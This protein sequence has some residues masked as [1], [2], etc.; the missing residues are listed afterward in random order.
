MTLFVVP[1]RRLLD[2]RPA[3]GVMRAHSLAIHLPEQESSGWVTIVTP[4]AAILSETQE[5]SSPVEAF[6][7]QAPGVWV[8]HGW[9][10]PLP[11]RLVVPT[12]KVLLLRP[13]RQVAAIT[14]TI[15]VPGEEDIVLPRRAVVQS[16]RRRSTISVRLYLAERRSIERESLWVLDGAQTAA[17]W[18]FCSAADERLTRRL[19]V[20]SITH[21]GETR[22]IVRTIG[23]RLPLAWPFTVVGYAPDPRIPG[24][25]VPANRILKPAIRARELARSLGHEAGHLTWVEPSPDRGVVPHS[26]PFSA[27]SPV[28]A[29]LEYSTVE[30]TP[31]ACLPRTEPFALMRYPSVATETALAPRTT[32]DRFVARSCTRGTPGARCRS[33]LVAPI[34]RPARIAPPSQENPASGYSVGVD[35]T[36]PV[37]R[38]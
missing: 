5:S 37:H 35:C 28:A 11:D 16:L 30:P 22:I 33:R 13:P 29:L 20:A 38:S 19:E 14:G 15:T 17:F 4:P 2:S 7:E 6:V 18:N 24:L 27:F 12:G 10:H 1:D 31:L 23:K 36:H 34:V 21:A 8:R 25:F 26:A 3:F 32:Q 9:S